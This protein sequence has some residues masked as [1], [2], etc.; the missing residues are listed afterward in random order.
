MSWSGRGIRTG[1]ESAGDWKV[2]QHVIKD[3]ITYS[4]GGKDSTGFGRFREV[5]DPADKGARSGHSLAMGG[6]MTVTFADA[7]LDRIVH[8]AYRFALEG[9]SMRKPEAE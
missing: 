4:G 3:I 1:Y 2:K 6:T 9:P 7:I 8:N 5:V